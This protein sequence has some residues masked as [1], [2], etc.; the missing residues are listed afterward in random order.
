MLWRLFGLFS[1]ITSQTAMVCP[2]LLYLRSVL[3]EPNSPSP[4]RVVLAEAQ[5]AQTAAESTAAREPISRIMT[6]H[7][8]A[9][10]KIC[11][12]S[13]SL[14]A[15]RIPM[16]GRGQTSTVGICLRTEQ[17]FQ[18]RSKK[19]VRARSTVALP[20]AES[21]MVPGIA[22]PARWLYSGGFSA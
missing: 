11:V 13:K 3:H 20:E 18:F 10:S 12:I 21:I 4:M 14:A 2:V 16:I 8:V 9:L 22:V 5:V 6:T 7:A 19:S 1:S 17:A 15:R